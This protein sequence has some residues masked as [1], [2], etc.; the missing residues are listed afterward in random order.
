ME[1]I[2]GGKAPFTKLK[3]PWKYIYTP[4]CLWEPYNWEQRHCGGHS[5]DII[6]HGK[7]GQGEQINYLSE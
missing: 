6:E 2:L 5:H 4:A 7:P 1:Y 3:K